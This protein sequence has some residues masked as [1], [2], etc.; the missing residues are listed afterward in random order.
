MSDATENSVMT[1][2]EII[3]KF[4]AEPLESETPAE[5][6]VAESDQPVAEAEA[7]EEAAEE[8][9]QYQPDFTFTVMDEKREFDERLRGYIKSKDEEDLIRD[10]YTKAA[11][12]DVVKSK[13]EKTTEEI[14]SLR[15]LENEYKTYNQG[16]SVLNEWINK[17]NKG[18]KEAIWNLIDQ[19]GLNEQQL[20]VALAERLQWDQNQRSARTATQQQALSQYQTTQQQSEIQMREERLMEMETRLG[21]NSVLSNPAVSEKAS[22]INEMLGGGNALFNE[23]WQ[24]GA[25]LEEQGQYP[26]YEEVANMVIG[27]YSKFMGTTAPSQPRQAP[28]PQK[29]IPNIRA[30]SETPELQIPTFDARKESVEDYM[31]RLRKLYKE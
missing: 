18:D 27:K 22:K 6:V 26:T 1:E 20:A 4:T 28:A 2:D 7:V 29:P 13:Y 10:L 9:Q 5:E 21:I 31:D 17:G 23:I 8:P 11:G 12:L 24:T 3:E 30:N 25:M 14:K 19:M 15:E 16:I